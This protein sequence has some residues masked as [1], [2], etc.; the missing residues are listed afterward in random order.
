M[1][2]RPHPPAGRASGEADGRR[3]SQGV[4]RQSRRT[5]RC[6]RRHV[7]DR[8]APGAT[9]SDRF[10]RLGNRNRLW[11]IVDLVAAA[12]YIV[13]PTSPHALFPTEGQRNAAPIRCHSECCPEETSSMG[14]RKP[15][16]VA[17]RPWQPRPAT[18]PSL[19]RGTAPR[20]GDVWPLGRRSRSPGMITSSKPSAVGSAC[21]RCTSVTIRRVYS[22]RLTNRSGFMA[23][24]KWRTF[25]GAS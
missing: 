9:R 8:S 21:T 20:C 10:P 6:D 19:W 7:D 3:F 18:R 11:K 16:A 1:Q 14:Y 5:H 4:S 12:H 17:A 25:C 24:T 22:S 15:A 2:I 13:R 23:M